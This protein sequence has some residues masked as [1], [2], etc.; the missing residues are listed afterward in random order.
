MEVSGLR[1]TPWRRY[2]HDRLYVSLPDGVN[3]A[4]FDRRSGQLTVLAEPYRAQA[5]AALAP[6]RA[7]APGPAPEPPGPPPPQ[8]DLALNRPGE[9]LHARISEL[10]PVRWREL[11]RRVLRRPSDV[12]RWRTGLRGEQIVAAELA[13]LTG[14]GWYVLHAVPLP[15]DVDIDHLLIGPG[16]VFCLNTK[17]HPKASVRVGDDMV[18]LG[19]QSYPHVRKSRREAVRASA[20]LSRHCGFPVPVQPVLVFVGAAK[21]TVSPTLRDVRVLRERQLGTLGATGGVLSPSAAERVHTTARNR[22]IWRT[23]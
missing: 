4:W 10:A 16:G 22:R 2:G 3:I 14:G 18:W 12:D 7:G 20:V 13:R 11:L 17:H 8:D 5:L 9:A 21:L 23:A 19:R 1:V 6:Y 15:R